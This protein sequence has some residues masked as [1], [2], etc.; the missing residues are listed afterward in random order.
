MN[1]RVCESPLPYIGAVC[2]NCSLGP[3]V[4]QIDWE[5]VL[6]RVRA[7]PVPPWVDSPMEGK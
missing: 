3:E 2:S 6:D 1:C 7:I 5:K 4:D